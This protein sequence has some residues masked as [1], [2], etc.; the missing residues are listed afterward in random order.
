[1]KR[2]VVPCLVL[3]AALWGCQNVE[4]AEP[5]NRKTFIRLFEGPTSYKAIAV[6]TTVEGDGYVILGTT[7]EEDGSEKT[8]ILRI[9][10]SGHLLGDIITLD[11]AIGKAI[12]THSGGYIVA[13]DSIKI[14]PDATQGG[15]VEISSMYLMFYD[16]AMA[17]I[18]RYIV[19]DQNPD[20]NA[21]KTDIKS[22]AITVSNT[23]QIIVLG[24]R[25]D[26]NAPKKPFV[27]ALNTN[28]TLAWQDDYEILELD[29]INGKSVHYSNGNIIW[30]SSIL[31]QQGNFSE[32]YISIPYVHEALTYENSSYYGE[33]QIMALFANDI[34]PSFVGSFGY[35]VIGTHGQTNGTEKDIF[36]ARISADGRINEQSVAFID[37]ADGL[38]QDDAVT[39]EDTG[40]ALSGSKDGGF[41]LAGTLL[42]NTS[43]GKGSR[44]VLL[45]RVDSFGEVIWKKLIGGSGDESVCSVRETKD[46]GILITGTNN[47]AGYSSIFVI[48]TDSRGELVN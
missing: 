12:K 47:I 46:G 40:D 48:K 24:T 42:T 20:E 30:A 2:A 3:M 26:D 32:S 31:K 21:V 16:N 45:I 10:E 14:D 15:N 25:Q 8:V 13:G 19:A 37:G 39:S 9:D 41:I 44:D 22:N 7:T 36:F 6:D 1:M 43:I 4:N 29:F 28:F 11:Q 33:D 23:G 38:V 27:L 34:Q 17:E 18:G 5:A 35:G